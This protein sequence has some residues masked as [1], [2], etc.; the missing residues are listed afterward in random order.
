MKLAEALHQRA[1]LQKRIAQLKQRLLDNA[2]VQEGEV[3]AEDPQELLAEL[4]RESG[5]LETLIRRINHTNCGVKHEGE[6]LTALL[7]RRDAMALRASVL[8]DFLA[9][10]SQKVDRFSHTEI[11]IQSAVPVKK[12]R[13]QADGLSK[14][15]RELE[16]TI[17]EKNWTTELL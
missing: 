4:E 15:L 9:A 8:R 11:R 14:E 12:L 7:A 3:P 13:A 2:K 6:S 17:Q 10:A 16:E 1:D 5:E